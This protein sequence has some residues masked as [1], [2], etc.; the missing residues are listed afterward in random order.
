MKVASLALVLAAAGASVSGGCSDTHLSSTHREVTVNERI[1]FG[2]CYAGDRATRS[3]TVT[4]GGTGWLRITA[5]ATDH[6]ALSTNFTGH[7]DLDPGEQLVV[8]VT[9]R[10]EIPGR[11]DTRLWVETSA[12]EAGLVEVEVS[13]VATPLPACDDANPCTE[14]SYDSNTG[15][16]RHQPHDRSCDDGNACTLNDNCGGG[17]CRG[18]PRFCEDEIDCTLDLCDPTFGCRFS[19]DDDACDDGDPCTRDVCDPDQGC[20]SSLA[21][22]GTS[23][24]PFT[25]AEDHRCFQGVCSLMDATGVSDG[26]PCSDGDPCTAGDSCEGGVCG[27]GSAAAGGG[28]II[29]TL[30][31]F[32]GVGSRVATDGYRYLFAD[33]D[34]LRITVETITGLEQTGRVDV[35]AFSPPVLFAPGRFLVVGLDG[36][37]ARDLK[38]MSRQ[39]G[40]VCF[41]VENELFMVDATDVTAPQIAWSSSMPVLA[42]WFMDVTPTGTVFLARIDGGAVVGFPSLATADTAGPYFAAIT[43]DGSSAGSW[44]TIG[45]TTGIRDLDA[46]GDHVAWLSDNRWTWARLDSTG[47]VLEQ[48]WGDLLAYAIMATGDGGSSAVASAVTNSRVSVEE[49]RMA[50]LHRRQIEVY[51]FLATGSCPEP[52]NSIC[53]CLWRDSAVSYESDQ[54]IVGPGWYQICSDPESDDDCPAG[55]S[56]ELVWA[57]CP[58]GPGTGPDDGPPPMCAG[59]D[60]IC[61]PQPELLA[62]V[63]VGNAA[64]LVLTWPTVF[65]AGANGISL[66]NLEP[67][68]ALVPT[69]DPLPAPRLDRGPSHLLAS[70]QIA[71]PI[72]YD[73]GFGLPPYGQSPSRRTGPLHGDVTAMVEIEGGVLLAGPLAA[74][75]VSLDTLTVESWDVSDGEYAGTAVRVVRSDNDSAAVQTSAYSQSIGYP[76]LYCDGTLVETLAADYTSTF[77]ALCGVSLHSFDTANGR[78]WALVSYYPGAVSVA[79]QLTLR[80]FGLDGFAEATSIELIHEDEWWGPVAV[81]TSDDGE[82][83]GVVAPGSASDTGQEIAELRIYASEPGDELGPISVIPMPDLTLGLDSFSRDNLALE[84]PQLMLGNGQRVDLYPINSTGD[85]SSL[86][87][88]EAN[89]DENVR[90]LWMRDGRAWLAWQTDT[91][92]SEPSTTTHRLSQVSY[93]TAGLEIVAN[94]ELDTRP[95]RV[96]DTGD[97][98]VVTTDTGTL[99]VAPA[100]PTE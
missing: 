26:L 6:P 28:E 13:G 70:G 8:A 54:T 44:V 69:L 78:L 86:Q 45:Q 94:I 49:D 7:R 40:G 24:G 52:D 47:F 60:L 19:P 11:L 23:C 41:A 17:Q 48:T 87:I 88:D 9:W 31:T 91:A 67:P 99:I 38:E 32:G 72:F 46:D 42:G 55:T 100:C 43:E 58:D 62:D 35:V 98:V 80:V 64:D 92:G 76:G 90:V 89:A 63:P 84:Y 34:A 59:L 83:V 68:S 30:E 61:V 39:M 37:T 20:T 56:C 5:I 96:L 65:T 82:H 29:A 22:D 53:L 2:S 81:C 3:L 14:D 66:Y 10:P 16:C 93:D 33:K 50:L 12:P 18:M 95:R 57:A 79:P 74:R 75:A 1:D 36:A 73:S 15:L 27:G 85:F 71:L 21:P 77:R 25:C 97:V 4:A 51:R